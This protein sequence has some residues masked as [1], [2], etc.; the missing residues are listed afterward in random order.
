MKLSTIL[1]APLHII[2]LC[3]PEARECSSEYTSHHTP[4]QF[5]LS[6]FDSMS[7]NILPVGH[8]LHC[9]VAVVITCFT[10]ACRTLRYLLRYLLIF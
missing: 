8:A 2:V 4:K 1:F 3:T 5:P 10:A 6:G 9:H 7:A